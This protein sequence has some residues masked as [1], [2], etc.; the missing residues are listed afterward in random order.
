MF[1]KFM[2]SYFYGKSGKGD[3]NKEDLPATRMQLFREMLRARLGGLMRLNLIYMVAWL[4]A[5][6]V[7]AYHALAFYA[8]LMGIGDLQAQVTAG[9][10][11]AADLA[12][13]QAQ[14]VDG[15]KSLALTGL[16]MMVPA[17]AI[18]GPSTAGLSLVTR[19]W[20]RDEHAF[21]WSDFWDALKANW[22]QALVLSTITGFTP[23]IVYVCWMFYGDMA[24]QNALFMV[25]QVLTLTVGVVWMLCLMYA[26]PMLVTYQLRLRDLLRNSLL[27]AIG[28]LPATLGLRLL[29]LVPMLIAIVVSLFTPYMQWALL[30]MFLYYLLYGFALSRFVNVSYVNAVFDK[31]INTKI[32][33]AQVNRGLF[34]E[35]E[36]DDEPEA[37]DDASDDPAADDTRA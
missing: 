34:T 18:T 31:Y 4:P 35:V 6:A 37:G 16:L 17:I 26:Y 25:P 11:A 22:K 3:Y 9:T 32:E 20:A 19:N 10:L 7:L 12:A 13:R 28:R 23:L 30:A 2:N 14:Y 8:L 33:G 27:L 24:Q 1:G 15:M 36:D 29:S 21:I 5:M